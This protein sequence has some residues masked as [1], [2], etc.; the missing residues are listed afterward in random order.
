M[1]KNAAE[2]V[3]SFDW[4]ANKATYINLVNLLVY[5][6]TAAERSEGIS[7][8]TGKESARKKP[9]STRVVPHRRGKLRLVKGLLPAIR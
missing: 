2:F 1:I 8:K 9:A 3:G 4:E 7:T 6:N 5:G